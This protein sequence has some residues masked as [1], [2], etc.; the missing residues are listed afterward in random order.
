M[1]DI[2]KFTVHRFLVTILML[3]ALTFIVYGL[4]EMVPANC[5]ERYVAYKATQGQ[6]LTEA[7]VR[8][9][10]IRMGL[11]KP[12]LQRWINWVKGIVT[13]GDLGQSCLWRVDVTA[14]VG[15]KFILSMVLCY[16]ALFL[17]YLIALPA[18]ILSANLRNGGVVDNSIRF[19]SYMGLALPNFFVALGIMVIA[20]VYFG[21]TLTGLFST[22]YADAPWS[23]D[24][25]LDMMGR[26]WLPVLVLAWSATAFQLQTIRAL[27]LD[28][29]DKLYVTAARARGITG[30]SLMMRYPA[31]HALTPVVNSIGYDL[32]RIFGDLP[33]VATV[34]SISD[35]GSLLLESLAVSNDQTVAGA[36]I[37]M[38][39]TAIVTLNFLTDVLLAIV[40]PRIR[41]S[42][43]KT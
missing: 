43:L 3:F 38:M 28:E 16:T 25:F 26:V 15:D 35:A 14:L 40:D 23:W 39:T 33:I 21:D 11:D 32:N 9:E 27:M 2:L 19:I 22:K 8:A 18:G 13:E 34:L 17:T 6:V 4:M 30:F 41:K 31:R 12:F 7:D 5:A 29:N 10:E 24:K 42:F 37:L 20:T 36:I 1:L